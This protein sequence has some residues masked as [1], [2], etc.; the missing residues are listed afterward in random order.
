MTCREAVEFI[1]DYLEGTLPAATRLEFERHLAVCIACVAYLRTYEQTIRVA[2]ASM[3]A[4]PPVP[5]EMVRAIL[6]SRGV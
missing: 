6:A 5:E 3:A 4:D 1:T 2:A